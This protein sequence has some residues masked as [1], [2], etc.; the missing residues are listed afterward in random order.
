MRA[1][2]SLTLASNLLHHPDEPDG[3]GPRRPALA[4]NLHPN[5]CA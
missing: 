4:P 1:V 3:G 5:E 2:R